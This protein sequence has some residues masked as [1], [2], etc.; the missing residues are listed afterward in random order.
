MLLGAG[1]RERIWRSQRS[2][3]H[4]IMSTKVG[5][6]RVRSLKGI[7]G[8]WKS[9]DAQ[10]DPKT[11]IS[12]LIL[13]QLLSNPSKSRAGVPSPLGRKMKH[14]EGGGAGAVESAWVW[15]GCGCAKW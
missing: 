4:P 14:T 10:V 12:A 5:V 8:S 6:S 11:W 2:A 9:P 7:W 15:P 13:F 3:H 1:E